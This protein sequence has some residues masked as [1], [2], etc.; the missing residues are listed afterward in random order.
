MAISI[1]SNR[2]A[3]GYHNM[4]APPRTKVELKCA[5][6][7]E[8]VVF[9]SFAWAL[10]TS[11]LGPKLLGKKYKMVMSDHVALSKVIP[12]LFKDPQDIFSKIGQPIYPTW[13]VDFLIG[14]RLL[15]TTLDPPPKPCYDPLLCAGVLSRTIGTLYLSRREPELSWERLLN[16]PV[17]FDDRVI[18]I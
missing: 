2:F 3:A 15:D 16:L 13:E 8:R 5:P 9:F 14:F 10:A 11:E 18:K 1:H 7:T 4:S 12:T 17:A 6:V